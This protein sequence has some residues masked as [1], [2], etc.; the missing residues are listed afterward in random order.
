MLSQGSYLPV[1]PVLPDASEV[2]P[3]YRRIRLPAVFPPVC[4]FPLP[5]RQFLLPGFPHRSEDQCHDSPRRR[6]R[7]PLCSSS[8][9]SPS[10][11]MSPRMATFLPICIFEDIKRGLH[12]HRG[13]RCSS[14][15]R[16]ACRSCSMI[17]NRP[18][19]MPADF[20][21]AAL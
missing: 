10:S 13:L 8:S 16:C 14:R 9:F 5:L 21:N 18:L 4:C 1:S 2:L 19:Q 17:W 12:G 3:V 6:F 7:L 20:L 11:P 15:P